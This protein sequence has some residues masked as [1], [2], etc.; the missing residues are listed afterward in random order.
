MNYLLHLDMQWILCCGI[1]ALLVGVASTGTLAADTLISVTC[2]PL[3]PVPTYTREHP[4]QVTFTWSNPTGRA[5]TM[6]WQQQLWDYLSETTLT[7]TH[8]TNL[9][10][11]VS[12]QETITIT[13]E[14]PGVYRF[15]IQPSDGIDATSV[16]CNFGYSRAPWP[17]DLPDDW[18]IAMHTI[19]DEIDGGILPDG[20]KWYRIFHTWGYMEPKQ[21]EYDW[22]AMDKM[23]RTVAEKGGKVLW[24]MQCTPRWSLP[25]AEGDPIRWEPRTLANMVNVRNRDAY[26]RFLTAFW[27][28]YGARGTVCPGVVDAIECW[29]ETNVSDWTYDWSQP[30]QMGEDYANF[31]QD[32]WE[33]TRANAPAVK[34]VGL[35]MS[36][37]QQYH[38]METLMDGKARNGKT[39]PAML[40]AFSAHTY[41]EMAQVPEQGGNNM[42]NQFLP[43][44]DRLR[45]RGYGTLAAWN[46][47]AGVGTVS[48]TGD[49]HITTQAEI[50]TRDA[51]T[52][53][54]PDHPHMLKN[55][56]WRDVSENRAAAIMVRAVLQNIDYGVS[57]I[58]LYRLRA[59][60][61]SFMYRDRPTLNYLAIAEL[62]YRLQPG[63][64]QVRK[65]D[66]LSG[67]VVDQ[68]GQLL[69]LWHLPSVKGE[70][71]LAYLDPQA[72]KNYA[73]I[74]SPD[75]Q[76]IAFTFN[77]K[78]LGIKSV[79]TSI[80]T[81]DLYG[82]N[83][84]QYP[85]TRDGQC[86]LPVGSDPVYI[87]LARYK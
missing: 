21:G 33:I 48:W 52:G 67:L 9:P 59:G 53:I 29:N 54:D 10:N 63:W 2:A 39:T 20:Y 62:A 66:N 11:A 30:K 77:L 23:V 68:Q 7:A 18:P 73:L 19:R 55:G 42:A 22:S 12:Y 69:H 84:Q 28:R 35:S 78:A 38:A 76:P 79:G 81:R 83:A 65:I 80:E 45:A 51:A 36:S 41:C 25:E 56:V 4:L 50:Q 46:T 64:R 8:T 16:H 72:T 31:V 5:R 17:H 82:R 47:E 24:V 75:I 26:R 37:G 34:I 87:Q 85:V 70:L 15:S 14:Q 1:F 44:W 32:T 6:V 57:N 27:E 60:D 71:L 40:D 49:H 43:L 58:F 3:S 61:N 86:T 13:P 74:W